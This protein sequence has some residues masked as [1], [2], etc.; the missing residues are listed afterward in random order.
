MLYPT[1]LRALDGPGRDCR[2]QSRD[3]HQ[4]AAY[5]VGAFHSS[6]KVWDDSRS[7]AAPHRSCGSC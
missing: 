1:E 4:R 7:I 3:L 2:T 6:W 5:F